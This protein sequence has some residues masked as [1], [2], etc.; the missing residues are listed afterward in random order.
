MSE[1]LLGSLFSSHTAGLGR[2]V[3]PGEDCHNETCDGRG[4]VKLGRTKI[5]DLMSSYNKSTV[6][7]NM[8]TNKANIELAE[9]IDKAIIQ[10]IDQ[11]KNQSIYTN[12]KYHSRL[13][14]NFGSL[15][16]Q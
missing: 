13:Q 12:I 16:T 1:Y 8:S 5:H 3:E 4:R 11:I 2:G 9:T 6:T 10:F 7:D 15:T 14:H